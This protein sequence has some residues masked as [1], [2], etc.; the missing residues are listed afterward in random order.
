MPVG[1][2][3]LVLLA[4]T[5]IAWPAAVLARRMR[6]RAAD[7]RKPDGRLAWPLAFLTGLGAIEFIAGLAL[8]GRDV[9]A[10]TPFIPGFGLPGAAAPLLLPWV[11][12]LL[13]RHLWSC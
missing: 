9:A 8:V 10:R 13:E 3:T 2:P 4:S 12:V 1:R 11:A 5:L 6:R 7:R